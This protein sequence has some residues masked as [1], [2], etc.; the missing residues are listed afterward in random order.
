MNKAIMKCPECGK[1]SLYLKIDAWIVRPI[2]QHY[3]T[4]KED[5]FQQLYGG[6]W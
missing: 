4:Y 6:V 5:E 2:K 3:R 1:H